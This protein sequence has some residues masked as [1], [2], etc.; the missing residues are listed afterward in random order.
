MLERQ[1]LDA[2]L[3]GA[4]YGELSS[5][6]EARL[7]AHLDSHPADRGAL[8]D[9]KS[10]HQTVRQKVATSRIFE[11]QMDPPQA[12]SAVLL[13][14]AARRA[15]KL[16]VEKPSR[17]HESW[18]QRFV[19][20]FVAHP[21]MAAAAT[22]VLV[23]GVGSMIYLKKGA[24]QLAEPTV[25]QTES[26]ANPGIVASAT[27]SEQG[28]AFGAA[29]GSATPDPGNTE[30]GIGGGG[31]DSVAVGLDD[32]VKGG[33]GHKGKLAVEEQTMAP[34][35]GDQFGYAEDG[36]RAEV[37]HRPVTPAPVAKASPQKKP[38]VEVPPQD[39]QPKDLDEVARNERAADRADK[40]DKAETKPGRF[41]NGPA[42]GGAP[43]TSSVT[44]TGSVAQAPTGQATPPAVMAEPP[45][46]PPKP[47][48]AEA[49]WAKDQHAKI[50]TLVKAGKCS[51]AVPLAKTLSARAPAYFAANVM[52]DRQLKSCMQYVN[53][54]SAEKAQRYREPAAA[55][56]AK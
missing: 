55:T 27:P 17:D 37:A 5:A 50:T 29:A 6:E 45:P 16:V 13:Q 33:E 19:R 32:N 15:P 53:D 36:K 46:P 10:A 42:G 41:A 47:P 23:V 8:D 12:L 18:F 26:A 22:L 35:G 28:R 44:T 20:S 7:S 30:G 40:A 39:T 31:K 52:N 21:A 4:L 1:D 11:L 25:A 56:K 43:T 49:A 38:Y 34:R 51:E 48:E 24:P 54:T 3:V 14:E 9:L 2:L